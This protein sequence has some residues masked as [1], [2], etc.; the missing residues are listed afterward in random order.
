MDPRISLIVV[1]PDRW[2]SM[3]VHVLRSPIV[4]L[5]LVE[6]LTTPT[7]ILG[8]TWVVQSTTPAPADL[9]MQSVVKR[10]DMLGW[11]RLCP[12]LQAKEPLSVLASQAEEQRIAESGQGLTLTVDYI[13]AHPRSQGIHLGQ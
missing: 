7:L 9:F 2:Q 4:W 8:T 12:A 11:H 3:I 10:D 6:V 5:G 1:N 13:G